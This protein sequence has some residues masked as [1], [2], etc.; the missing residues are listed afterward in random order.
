LTFKERAEKQ[1]ESPAPRVEG[2]CRN[3]G[4]W[5]GKLKVE[6]LKKKTFKP[7]D[8]IPN[9]IA[10]KIAAD[11]FEFSKHAVDQMMQRRILVSEVKEALAASEVLE[12]Y[13]NDKYGPSCLV[14]AFSSKGKALHVVCTH[15]DRELLKIITVYEPDPNLW[16]EFRTRLADY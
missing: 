10:E 1:V 6:N 16:L 12:H 5:R 3:S 4:W 11:S 8:S 15:P 9:A 14:L 2:S 13:P 7:M